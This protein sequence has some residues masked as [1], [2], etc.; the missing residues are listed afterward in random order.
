MKPW[1]VLLLALGVLLVWIG[2][3]RP[4]VVTTTTTAAVR[5]SAHTSA[6]RESVVVVQKIQ[7]LRSAQADTLARLL[8]ERARRP[9]ILGSDTLAPAEGMDTVNSADG[10]P[11]SACISRDDLAGAAAHAAVDSA[12]RIADAWELRIQSTTIDSL[13]QH[14]DQCLDA[15]PRFG[16]R[17]GFAAGLTVGLLTCAATR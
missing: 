12:Q 16:F 1:Q 4:P 17:S 15:Q 8:R 3:T 10:M 9:L 7:W 2:Y 5:D 14:L 6:V 11:D 13:T